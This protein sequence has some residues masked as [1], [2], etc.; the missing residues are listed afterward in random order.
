MCAQVAPRDAANLLWAAAV[1][2]VASAAAVDGLRALCS[3]L[4]GAELEEGALARLFQAHMALERLGAARKQ[5][6]GEGGAGKLPGVGD[7]APLRLLPSSVLARGEAAWRCLLAD[8]PERLVREPCT[9]W[10]P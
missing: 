5:A 4:E 9:R 7:S 6:A 2:D 3:Q 8:A 1:L 10:T